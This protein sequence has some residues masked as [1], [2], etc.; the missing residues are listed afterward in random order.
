MNI[1][2]YIRCEYPKKAV[3]ALCRI[4]DDNISEI[5]TQKRTSEVTL[6][7]TLKQ[8]SS[9]SVMVAWFD[10]DKLLEDG[11]ISSINDTKI[12]G[13]DPMDYICEIFSDCFVQ[14]ISSE[15][16][17]NLLTG[18]Y[19]R[20]YLW[21]TRSSSPSYV[22]ANFLLVNESKDNLSYVELP[23]KVQNRLDAETEKK[24]M[25]DVKSTLFE[26]FAKDNVLTIVNDMIAKER[27]LPM[28]YALQSLRQSIENNHTFII[29]EELY[30]QIVCNA[31]NDWLN[32]TFGKCGLTFHYDIP[33]CTE[34]VYINP[35][36][37]EFNTNE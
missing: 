18:K 19:F 9:T 23:K 3:Y 24:R 37:Y 2:K 4:R 6:E 26:S 27:N 25:I 30:R 13:K 33:H 31:I 20:Q 12:D 1:E 32:K 21:N 15:Q 11:L 28:I 29:D 17:V 8:M 34:S 16:K 7:W 35:E 36:H 14:Y 22:T 5:L 10:V